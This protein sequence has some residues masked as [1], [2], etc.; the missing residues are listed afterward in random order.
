MAGE[1][2]RSW[3][4]LAAY[5]VA[6]GAFVTLTAG[7]I[8][9]GPAGPGIAA[10][11]A[12][13]QEVWRLGKLHVDGVQGAGLGDLHVARTTLS[14]ARGVWAVGEDL[15]IA[16]EPLKLLIGDVSL[17]GAR[18]KKLIVLR[19]PELGPDKGGGPVTIDTQIASV[20]IDEVDMA[21]GVGGGAA[22][23]H[24]EGGTA[25]NR[26]GLRAL[27]LDLVRFDAPLDKLHIDYVRAPAIK[28]DASIVGKAGGFFANIIGEPSSDLNVIAHIGGDKD[29]GNGVLTA[30][31]GGQDAGHA[32]LAW[33]PT[34][35]RLDAEGHPSVAPLTHTLAARFGPLLS[36]TAS[37][38]ALRPEGAPFR[39]VLAAGDLTGEA[40]GN[41]DDDAK[42][43]GAV[44]L[45]L[46]ATKLSA[47]LP[48]L[49]L[50]AGAGQFQGAAELS[51]G[52]TRIS[53]RAN[54][55]GWQRAGLKL[56]AEGP[57][58]IKADAQR[59][60]Y[61]LDVTSDHVDAPLP[62]IS[63]LLNAPHI[64]LRGYYD[65]P[66]GAW[67]FERIAAVGPDF[68]LRGAGQFNG[69]QTL[70]RGEWR[71]PHLGV[72]L[73]DVSGGAQGRW[74]LQH[75]EGGQ[76]LD[77]DGAG[78]NVAGRS[79]LAL[80]LGATPKIEAKLNFIGPNGQLQFARVNG[81]ALRMGASGMFAGAPLNVRLEAST[82]GPVQI[83][84][85]NL[86]GALDATGQVIG[87]LAAPHWHFDA[88]L[89]ALDVAGARVD[90]AKVALDLANQRA[91]QAGHV[92]LTG[93]VSQK[94]LTASA[95]L[96]LRG[97]TMAF[98]TL[99]AKVGQLSANGQA[100]F[101]PRG[102]D[103]NVHLS[104]GLDGLLPYAFGNIDGA[105]TL[106]SERKGAPL[107]T[108]DAK[109]VHA[110]YGARLVADTLTLHAAGPLN[111][112]NATFALKGWAAEDP[113]ELDGTARAGFG[114]NGFTMSA[115]ATGALAGAKVATRA[116][117]T[118][119]VD[120][121]L[122]DV[123][124]ALDLGDGHA[125]LAWRGAGARVAASG[126]FDHAPLI[127]LT[128]FMDQPLAG[129][130]TGNAKLSGA[131]SSLAGDMDVT[132][133]DA[134]LARRSRETVDATIKATLGGGMLR[135]RIDAKSA[136]GLVASVEGHAPVI[137]QAAPF[138]L[139]AA[140]SGTGQALWSINGPVGGLWALFGPLD[141]SLTGR[142][143]G[144]GD[145]QFGRA[146]VSGSGALTIAE[147]AFED[148]QTG[149]KLRGMAARVE[150]DP[151]GVH[152][153]SFSAS[154]GKEGRV[155]GSGRLDGPNNGS[156]DLTLAGMRLLDRADARAR[157]GGSVHVLWKDGGAALTGDIALTEAEMRTL[158]ASEEGAVPM[159]D[160]VE[161]NRP[162]PPP[163]IVAPPS[164]IPLTL[165]LRVHAPGRVFTRTRGL[166]AEWSLDVRVRG[167]ANAPLLYGS[168]Q[169]IRGSFTLAGRRFALDTG[170][171]K[172]AGDPG[173]AE[174]YLTA[175]ADAPDLTVHVSVSGSASDPEIVLTSEPALPEDEILPQLLFGSSS[176]DLSP[177]AAAQL[178]AS[179]ATLTGRSAFDLAG[180]ARA[181]VDLDRLEVRQGTGGFLVAGGKYLTRDV[182]LELSR[183]SLG[184]TS[185][186]V[187]WQVR[188]RLYVISSFA[189]GGDQRVALRWKRDY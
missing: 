76:T 8:V 131:K 7:A 69:A 186:S 116:P 182:Y 101:G 62:E 176:R 65:R 130:I 12:N 122:L 87:S 113:L 14:D 120:D 23:F 103:A 174:V 145:A 180:A 37:G 46:R 79:P 109:M 32:N 151:R 164:K 162:G 148:K 26:G 163:R 13:G 185:T 187:E 25:T 155:T 86:S 22:R 55:E 78:A 15:T 47:L 49:Q 139:A 98:D 153:A 93:F 94:P 52:H 107:T 173:D 85:V 1:P 77:V 110:R 125:D 21:A 60:S 183:G 2:K 73:Q 11:L 64:T 112:M 91:G 140:P 35:W 179:L 181:A 30:F 70:F 92:T 168:A 6:G 152:L 41:L 135:G 137:A 166:D 20:I 95:D 59:V 177:L 96:S 36:L 156:L 9:L 133:D 99:N 10:S 121:G 147:G 143:D 82:R 38:D 170:E 57:I 50:E 4:R 74:T 117:V 39:A 165:D 24:I 16:W 67:L 17:K 58:E 149:V 160:V 106:A 188:P 159:I 189:A 154:D 129:A 132:L 115:N 150:F 71:T 161:I 29:R 75:V 118:L 157:G 111:A 158:G 34:G 97:E 126:A 51:E 138:R 48:E 3:K 108:L 134:R 80:L 54:L 40:H 114:K 66:H 88:Q 104:G 178:A 56:S 53:G 102:P 33:A 89:G 172:F 19:R 175:T 141:Q 72:A 90:N 184:E 124:A 169:L 119:R 81:R 171:T 27:N 84:G 100:A 146:G 142:M 127:L 44:P 136:D 18:A 5:G 61:D 42:A 83:A 128:A 28:L 167:D 31:I 45:S 105:L 144:S 43:V 68:D 123:N 63:R